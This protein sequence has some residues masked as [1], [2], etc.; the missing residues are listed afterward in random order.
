M[1]SVGNQVVQG[2][3]NGIAG[4]K[5]PNYYTWW[6]LPFVCTFLGTGVI[7]GY[8]VSSIDTKTKKR[9]PSTTQKGKLKCTTHQ[10]QYPLWEKV[11]TV[12]GISV[13]VASIVASG[14]YRLGI[15]WYNPKVAAGL[16]AVRLA[17]Q[18]FT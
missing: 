13:V 9:C 7:G 10:V 3:Q 1:S 17:Q 5:A 12:V 2:V 8:V 18:A 11:I 14:L 15:K 4:F 16:E 6:I